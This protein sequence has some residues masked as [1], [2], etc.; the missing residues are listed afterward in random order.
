M[1][2]A[3]LA[4]LAS[5][6][7]AS[8]WRVRVLVVEGVKALGVKVVDLPVLIALAASHATEG[9]IGREGGREGGGERGRFLGMARWEGQDVEE[10]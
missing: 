8:L 9:G 6:V 1:A 5:V 7:C 2:K 10:V 4:V 3:V